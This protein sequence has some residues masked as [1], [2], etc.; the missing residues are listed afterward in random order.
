MLTL[1]FAD[2]GTPT[3]R[4]GRKVNEWL[5]GAGRVCAQAFSRSDKQWIDFPGVGVFAFSADSLEVW[6]WPEPHASIAS[7]AELI[8]VIITGVRIAEHE[9]SRMFAVPNSDA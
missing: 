2:T 1:T 5:D 6:A 4:G 3:P 8:R 9:N 7:S